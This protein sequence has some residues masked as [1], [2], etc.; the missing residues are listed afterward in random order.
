[1]EDTRVKNFVGDIESYLDINPINMI[2]NWVTEVEIFAT[3]IILKTSIYVYSDHYCLWQLFGKDGTY[4]N[5]T[6]PTE[7]CIY[8]LHILIETIIKL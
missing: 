2:G 6:K 1:M 3:A 4:K 8:I 5:G 7:N